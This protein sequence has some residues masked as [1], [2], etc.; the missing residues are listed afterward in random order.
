[1]SS[2]QTSGLLKALFMRL[3]V[4][5]KISLAKGRDNHI[6]RAGFFKT[7]SGEWLGGQGVDPSETVVLLPLLHRLAS[8]SPEV[9]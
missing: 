6:C 1:M 8:E 5:N 9:Q 4:R 7:E 3:E 2:T